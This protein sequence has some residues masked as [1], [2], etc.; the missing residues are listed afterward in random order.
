TTS[1]GVNAVQTITFNNS[2]IGG[3]F[4]LTFNGQPTTLIPYS[5]NTATLA[6]NILTALGALSSING[7]SNITVSS[8]AAPVVTFQN[9]LGSAPQQLLL[10]SPF[11][12]GG[13]TP[14]TISIASTTT[15]VL[16]TATVTFQNIL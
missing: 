6:G 16:P 14:A 3:S 9:A 1:A 10:A 13:A 8:A 7:T 11:L 5:A 12:T 15:G 4:I 2:P